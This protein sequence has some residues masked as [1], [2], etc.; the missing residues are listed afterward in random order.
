MTLPKPKPEL[1]PAETAQRIEVAGRLRSAVLEAQ[2]R[3]RLHRLEAVFTNDGII[4][5]E[6]VGLTGGR[7]HSK[8]L[9]IFASFEYD[10]FEEAITFVSEL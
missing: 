9:R 2:K 7:Q 8:F 5:G 3:T 1:D 4:V 10:E 6:F